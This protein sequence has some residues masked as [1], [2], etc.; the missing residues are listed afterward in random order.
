ML[1]KFSIIIVYSIF[2]GD[3]QTVVNFLPGLLILFLFLHIFNKP[4]KISFFNE[5]EALSLIVCFITYYCLIY[6]NRI[7][8]DSFKIFFIILISISNIA[9]LLVWTL[10]YSL[11][12]KK[13][14]RIFIFQINRRITSIRK[15]VRNKISINF[16]IFYNYFI[17]VNRNRKNSSKKNMI[18]F[19]FF[20]MKSNL[21]II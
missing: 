11:V 14:A 1:R 4:Y 15:A 2:R 21:L 8:D 20:L 17:K 9:F 16:L 12:I 10:A 6:Y 5:L 13:K 7:I 18:N 19:Y 3:H